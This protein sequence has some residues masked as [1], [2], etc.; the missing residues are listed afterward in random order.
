MKIFGDSKIFRGIM[1]V[2]GILMMLN[3]F[4][5]VLYKVYITP[6]GAEVQREPVFDKQ[7]AETFVIPKVIPGPKD[8][9]IPLG[10]ETPPIDMEW[11]DH[12]GERP[13]FFYHKPQMLWEFEVFRVL[14]TTAD[15]VV[16]S[17]NYMM[18]VTSY[19][20]TGPVWRVTSYQEGKMVGVTDHYFLFEDDGNIYAVE[21]GDT[22]PGVV[23]SYDDISEQ[24]KASK[25]D[26]KPRKLRF[27]ENVQINSLDDEFVELSVEGNWLYIKFNLTAAKNDNIPLT[28]MEYRKWYRYGDDRIFFVQE[29]SPI[30]DAVFVGGIDGIGRVI[31]ISFMGEFVKADS[32]GIY[33]E[34]SGEIYFMSFIPMYFDEYAEYYTEVPA[35]FLEYIEFP[36]EIQGSVNDESERMEGIHR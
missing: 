27:G 33:Y 10:V 19:G 6:E 26:V 2:L 9:P 3:A 22:L 32:R 35:E 4:G 7:N 17:G 36:T 23:H 24:E 16:R 8:D 34:R 31:V 14:G 28:S 30:K 25:K 12:E 5:V 18:W 1:M 11:T 20:V 29:R 21:E 13:L 15:Y